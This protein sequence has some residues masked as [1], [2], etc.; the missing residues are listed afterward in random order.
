M[1]L[2]TRGSAVDDISRGGHDT[3]SVESSKRIIKTS[4][5]GK[6]LTHGGSRSGPASLFG[7]NG[8]SSSIIEKIGLGRRSDFTDIGSSRGIGGDLIARL[9]DGG[10][11]DRSSGS[12][13]FVSKSISA[14]A[15]VANEHLSG[16]DG[17]TNNCQYE[18]GIDK[19]CGNGY[20]CV[21]NGCHSNCEVVIKSG[22]IR[23]MSGQSLHNLETINRPMGGNRHALVGLIDGNQAFS[24]S[25]TGI[26]RG[27][28]SSVMETIE[29]GRSAIKGGSGLSSG[30]SENHITHG[31]SIATGHLSGD[32]G[33]SSNCHYECGQDKFCI[34]GYTCVQ[35]G[36]HSI[37]QV[38]I[39]SG[40]GLGVSGQNVGH[41]SNLD[42]RI[43]A[44]SPG[45]FEVI[46]RT[47]RVTSQGTVD[48]QDDT[49]G[50]TRKSFIPA[51]NTGNSRNL[52]KV[53]N[54]SE[55]RK[56]CYSDADCTNNRS[57][58]KVGCHMI[59][60]RRQATNGYT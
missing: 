36:C 49:F 1:M 42:R 28:G 58:A 7:N 5:S 2:D 32:D 21:Q 41:V 20:V 27:A 25:R 50:R 31:S 24:N 16:D 55:C 60:R 35:N 48:L 45:Q 23:E 3:I 19:Q 44:T 8:R 12:S 54:K 10:I 40:V 47:R 18:C 59:C 9:N 43:G 52:Q 22:I 6:R 39:N 34:E 17:L 15:L 26:S 53:S 51:V 29:L 37:C 13:A 46:D 4:S 11:A 30:I 56:Q 57:C 33:L 38:G 14:A